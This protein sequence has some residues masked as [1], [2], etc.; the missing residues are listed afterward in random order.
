MAGNIDKD[1]AAYVAAYKDLLV[2]LDA[3]S[4]DTGVVTYKI[5][6]QPVLLIGYSPN[7]GSY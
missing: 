6:Q 7:G 2:A 5:R 1:D 4:E 3:R